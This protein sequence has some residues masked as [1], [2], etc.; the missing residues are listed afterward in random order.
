MCVAVCVAVCGVRCG[1][2]VTPPHGVVAWRPASACLSVLRLALGDPHPPFGRG[3]IRPPEHIGSLRCVAET[4]SLGI[5]GSHP[6]NTNQ[7]PFVEGTAVTTLGAYNC[8]FNAGGSPFLSSRLFQKDNKTTQ[9]V[10]QRG[11][12]VAHRVEV[13]Q[14]GLDFHGVLL[15]PCGVL[16]V[17]H[18]SEVA[19]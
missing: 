18:N 11:P 14:R 2:R 5:W 6:T 9:E 8:F 16:E 19:C 13:G 3:T 4:A 7:K 10:V 12:L 1:A 17:C 15:Q